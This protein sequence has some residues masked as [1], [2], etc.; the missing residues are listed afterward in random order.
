MAWHYEER[1][2]ARHRGC[3]EMQVQ[4]GRL[5]IGCLALVTRTP[6]THQPRNRSDLEACVGT[7]HLGQVLQLWH[8]ALVQ[9]KQLQAAQVLQ[10]EGKG[11][12]RAQGI[13]HD[14]SSTFGGGGGAWGAEGKYP[15]RPRPHLCTGVLREEAAQRTQRGR[16]D[17]HLLGRVVDARDGLPPAS[18]GRSGGS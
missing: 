8:L 17:L 2:G 16:P 1:Q 10:S 11:G 13:G 9:V 5:A 4:G 12:G 3:C 6:P 15:I 18:G 14:S 7:E